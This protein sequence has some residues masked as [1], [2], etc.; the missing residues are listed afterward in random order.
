M[1]KTADEQWIV[2][3]M[4]RSCGY[5]PTHQPTTPHQVFL[6]WLVTGRTE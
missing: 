5:R 3:E 2:N 6:P 4:V 1:Q